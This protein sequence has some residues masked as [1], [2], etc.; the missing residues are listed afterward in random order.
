MNQTIKTRIE[1]IGRGKVPEGYKKTKVGIVP[2]DWEETRFKK[3]FSRLMRKNREGNDN[4]LTISAQYGLIS[5][6]DF[7][8]K[9]IASEDKSNYFLLHKGEF[10]YNKSYSN[11]YPYGA[12]KRLDFYEKGIV[13]PLYICFAKT[14]ENKCSDFYAH[15][16]EGGLM[17]KE[18]KAFAQEGARNHGLLNIAVEDFFNAHL[19]NPPIEEQEKIAEI[20]SAQDKLISLKEKLIEQ[21]KQQK[22]YLMQQ[23]LTG[24]KR[25]PGFT[26]EWEEV[27]MEDVLVVKNGYAF[28]SKEYDNAN[29]EFKIITIKNVKDGYMDLT[30]C[31][32]IAKLP[33]D[34]QEH[35]ILKIGDVLVSLTGNVGRVCIVNAEKTLLNQRVGKLH[36]FDKVNFEFL[37]QQLRCPMFLN[38]M[39]EVATGAAQANLSI[40]D[41]YQYS[42]F[43]PQNIKEQQAIADIL[44]Q[45]DEEIELLQKNLEEEKNKKKALMQLLLTGIVRV[46]EEG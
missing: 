46:Q 35:Q 28:K 14:E 8:N 43:C 39:M 34:I 5:Q 41:I 3:M 30:Q 45:A 24:K 18:I 44:S 15:Y 32:C 10:A 25:L 12:L 19:L 22:K 21:K 11:G 42:F 36:F 29:G 38:N 17:N 2:K 33:E 9:S 20:L 23:L 1:Q 16:F 26:G 7:F 6:S 37:Y 40:N 13:S 4:V 27:Q 31:S